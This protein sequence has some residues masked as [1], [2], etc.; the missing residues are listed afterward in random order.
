MITLEIIVF[1][2]GIISVVYAKKENI[3]VYPTGIIC[4]VITVYILL[5]AQYFGDM[6]M[7]IYYSSMSLM[8]GGT[9]QDIKMI[10]PELLSP[11]PIIEKDLLPAYFF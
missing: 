9:G 5:K 6:M 8:D 2:F 7:N 10:I 4:T 11:L 1:L 3:L